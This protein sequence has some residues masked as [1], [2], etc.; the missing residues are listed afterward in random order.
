MSNAAVHFWRSLIDLHLVRVVD[1]AA[2]QYL[3]AEARHHS[4]VDLPLIGLVLGLI[5]VRAKSRSC[6]EGV[7]RN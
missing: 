3:L 4:W 2:W 7:W 1:Q 5:V 6:T